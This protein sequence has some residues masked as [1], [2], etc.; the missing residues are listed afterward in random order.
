MSNVLP[1]DQGA[2]SLHNVIVWDRIAWDCI[3]GTLFQSG[4]VC[5]TVFINRMLGMTRT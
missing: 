5:K 4:N 1:L 2:T 3:K